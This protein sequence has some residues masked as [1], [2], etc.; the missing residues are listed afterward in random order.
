MSEK[1][2]KFSRIILWTVSTILIL[3]LLYLISD[4][5]IIVIISIL[6]AFIFEPFVKHLEKQGFNRLT[7]TAIIYVVVGFLVYILISVLAP[8]LLSQMDQLIATFNLKALENQIQIFE[9]EMIKYFPFFSQGEITSGVTNFIRSWVSNPIDKVT[10][11]LSSIFS[12]AAISVIVPFITFFLLKDSKKIFKAIMNIMP[13]KYFEMSYWI[14]KKISVQLGRFVR[15]WIFDATFVGL[16]CGL[17]FNF[18]GVHYA[19]P[20][21]IIAGVGH[22]VPYLGPLF[23]GIPAIII[24][25]IQYGDLSKVPLLILLIVIV[26]ALDNGLV[27]PY[28][29]AKS[30]NMHPIIIILLIIAGGQLFGIIGMLLAVPTATVVRTAIKEIYFAL[31]NYKIAKT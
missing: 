7:S 3:Y 18:I 22:L 16:S 28:I 14:L 15:A 20:L 29:F 17:G 31:R 26:Y 19:L 2:I 13:N 11:I 8:K 12:V 4:I 25:V 24:S 23:G 5:I 21:G 10:T 1:T 30:T 6:I 9:D 27:Q